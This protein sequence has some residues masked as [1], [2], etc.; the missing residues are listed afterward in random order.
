M[1]EISDQEMLELVQGAV[2]AILRGEREVQVGARTYSDADLV[3]LRSMERDY[4][5]RVTAASRGGG[6][7]TSRFSP[8]G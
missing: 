2:A 6:I 4:R 5:Q 7:F 3:Q 1:A 8:I